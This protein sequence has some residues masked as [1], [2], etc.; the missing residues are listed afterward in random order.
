MAK[1]DGRIF[2]VNRQWHD[3]TGVPIGDGGVQDWL[4]A[5]APSSRVDAGH[6]WAES[7]RSGTPLEMELSLLGRDGQCRPF[8]TRAIPLR[9][10]T[11]TVYRWIGTHIDISEQ[12]RREEQIRFIVSELSHRTKNLLAVVVAIARQT[13][14]YAVD[15]KQYQACFVERLQALEHCHD[16]LVKDDWHGATLQDLVTVQM[17]PFDEPNSGR[18]DEAGPPVVL[19]PNA[20]Q[21]LGLALH[22]LATNASKHGAL[23]V[24]DGKVV[25]RWAVDD[26][27]NRVRFSW[28]ETG[29]PIIVQPQRKGFGRLVI[30]EIVPRALNGSGSL[31]FSASGVSWTFEFPQSE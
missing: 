18:I 19:K 2:W 4:T 24:P 3:Y 11:S 21:Y 25:I 1:A 6:G 26:H 17:S 22:E 13:A 29:G 16:L 31:D 5:L 28:C 8:L 10:T 20:V 27:D 9:D 15:V 23:S 30:E 14:Q 12:K 7:L